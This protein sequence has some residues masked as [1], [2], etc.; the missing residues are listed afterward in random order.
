MGDAFVGL[1]LIRKCIVQNA[2][3]WNLFTL[4][5]QAYSLDFF[6]IFCFFKTYRS[7]AGCVDQNFRSTL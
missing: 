3:L 4:V 2:K 5:G 6:E 7:F 1:L